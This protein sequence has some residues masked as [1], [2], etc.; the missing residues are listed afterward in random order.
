MVVGGDRADRGLLDLPIRGRVPKAGADLGV[1]QIEH[2]LLRAARPQQ[3][4][5]FRDCRRIQRLDRTLPQRLNPS[6]L[7][8]G[9]LQLIEPDRPLEQ[10]DRLK[11]QIALH[12]T[13]IASVIDEL[14]H[15]A[16]P[17]SSA[18]ISLHRQHQIPYVHSLP[19]DPKADCA[20]DGLGTA[21]L[22]HAASKE[23]SP[24]TRDNPLRRVAGVA[25]VRPPR[26]IEAMAR[27]CLVIIRKPPLPDGGLPRWS[28]V[29]RP[30][31]TSPKNGRPARS[32]SNA[33]E[34]QV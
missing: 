30:T 23:A 8:P 25:L 26:R 33:A 32:S 6:E 16:Y 1:R 22:L 15:L 24:A 3:H 29:I 13:V 21:P 20:S 5:R 2:I 12:A 34:S 14:G 9:L 18:A 27:S 7:R 28:L 10:L 11:D 4:A 17:D 19:Q 31:D